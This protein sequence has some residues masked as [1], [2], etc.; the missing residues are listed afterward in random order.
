MKDFKKYDTLPVPPETLYLTLTNH[1][2]IQ[3]WTGE[4]AQMSTEPGVRVLDVEWEHNRKK[5][6]F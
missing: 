2:T 5:P 1:L 4:P 6:R 3:L